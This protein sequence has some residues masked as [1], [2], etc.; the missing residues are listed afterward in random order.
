MHYSDL[1]DPELCRLLSEGDT[2]AYTAIYDR[3]KQ[4]LYLH[5]YRKLENREEARDVVQEL[6]TSLWVSRTELVL[7]SSLSGYLFSAVRNRVI[8]VI[9]HQGVEQK[10]SRSLGEFMEQGVTTTD[11]R[12]REKELAAQ[13]N[14]EIERLPPKMKEIFQLSRESHLSHKGI[15]DKLSLS[16]QTVRTQVRN[17]LRILRIKLGSFQVIVLQLLYFF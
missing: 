17:A 8:N 16:E 15:A 3:Y 1:S 14:R 5:A 12:I 13:I 6:F 9:I 2:D 10:Y 4:P 7:S 11:E